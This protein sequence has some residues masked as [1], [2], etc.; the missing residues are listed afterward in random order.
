LITINK[1]H[2]LEGKFLDYLVSFTSEETTATTAQKT[3]AAA[4]SE[5]EQFSRG[6]AL[7]RFKQALQAPEIATAIL[8]G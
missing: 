6:K 3:I 7:K 8:N 1:R 2:D 4:L 5:I